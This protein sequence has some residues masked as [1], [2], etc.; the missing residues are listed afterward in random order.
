MKKYIPWVLNA[1]FLSTALYL[2]VSLVDAGISLDGA[3]A[4]NDQLR[5]R[6]R[7]SLELVRLGWVGRSRVD[8]LRS[9]DDI[10]IEGGVVKNGPDFVEV[11][12]MVFSISDNK[13]SDV[14]YMD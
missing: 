3:R 11:G 8:L 9:V 2:F 4:R 5:E 10:K 6:G 14:R 1:I 13:V 7:V 12:E